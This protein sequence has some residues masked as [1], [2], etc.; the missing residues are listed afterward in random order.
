M[1]AQC[2]ETTTLTREQ[3]MLHSAATGTS[4]EPHDAAADAEEHVNDKVQ[5]VHDMMPP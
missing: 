2:V 4:K 3:L 1:V 5:E